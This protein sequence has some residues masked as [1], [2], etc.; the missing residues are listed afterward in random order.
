MLQQ[1]QVATVLTYFPRFIELFPDLQTLA[2]A[3]EDAVLAAWTGLGYYRRAR[4]LL[5][6][7]RQLENEHGGKFP[8]DI[9]ALQALPGI[10]RSTA[11]AILALAFNERATILDGNV[12][13]VLSRLHGI[14]EWP[15]K[16][17]VEK[18]LWLLAQAHTPTRDVSSYTQAIMDLGATLCTRREP[19][20]QRCPV[21]DLCSAYRLDMTRQTPAPAPPKKSPERGAFM[22]VAED[23]N[24]HI[25][26]EK[27]AAQGVWG[28]L[29]CFPEYADSEGA[30]A[31]ALNLTGK[32][33]TLLPAPAQMRH[34]FTH[35]RLILTLNHVR[36]S[37]RATL[38]VQ[39]RPMD[40]FAPDELSTVGLAAPVVRLLKPTI[41]D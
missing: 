14:T 17:D 5:K 7:A 30:E 25:L 31:A 12:K 19:M 23:D 24:G 20:C 26:L 33:V 28:G 3:E 22:L 10:G 35:Y 41:Q 37:E 38:A 6:A 34:Q 21:V 29:W 39:E 8:D 15:G 36:I 18:R 4:N 16:R 40:W 9:E 11:G 27:R 2:N 13:R 1:T 32:V